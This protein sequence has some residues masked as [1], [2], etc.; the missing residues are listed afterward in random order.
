MAFLL[1]TA[2]MRINIHLG[3]DYGACIDDNVTISRR[4]N[5]CTAWRLGLGWIMLQSNPEPSVGIIGTAEFQMHWSALEH[6]RRR[7]HGD[8]R[9]L[10]RIMIADEPAFI[11]R[12]RRLRQFQE[13]LYLGQLDDKR[14]LSMDY[15]RQLVGHISECSGLS[16]QPYEEYFSHVVP[17]RPPRYSM[18]ARRRVKTMDCMILRVLAYHLCE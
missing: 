6:T 9:R 4:H 8:L 7:K 17:W 18:N 11:S 14:K 3:G 1:W 10:R 5:R 15:A 13:T 16:Y 12:T 2:P